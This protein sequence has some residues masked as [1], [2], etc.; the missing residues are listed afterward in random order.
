MP[1]HTIPAGEYSVKQVAD[2]LQVSVTAVLK[3][4]N[5]DI[6][7]KKIGKQFVIKLKSP[8]DISIRNY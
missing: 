1:K 3:R 4:I 6:P 8:L 5:K 7:A 2:I